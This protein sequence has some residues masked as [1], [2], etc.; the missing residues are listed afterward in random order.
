MKR[1]EYCD[2]NEMKDKW[3]VKLREMSVIEVKSIVKKEQERK[4]MIRQKQ[5]LKGGL[6]EY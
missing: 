2:T 3:G 5:K 4:L 6:Y 1:V